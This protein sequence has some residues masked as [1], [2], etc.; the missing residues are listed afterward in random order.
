MLE[1]ATVRGDILRLVHES[2]SDNV[3]LGA[4]QTLKAKYGFTIKKNFIKHQTSSAFCGLY[5]IN[6][7]RKMLWT[8]SHLRDEIFMSVFNHPGDYN[9]DGLMGQIYTTTIN[10]NNDDHNLERAISTILQDI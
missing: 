1:L 7:I 4:A 6:F 3:V 5:T 10:P 9:V 8:P 2:Y